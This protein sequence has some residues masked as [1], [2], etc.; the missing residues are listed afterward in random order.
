MRDKPVSGT[1]NAPDSSREENNMESEE[2][3]HGRDAERPQDIPKSG[4]RDILLR[5]KR[6]VSED[7]LSI[8]AAGVAFYGFLAIFPALAALVSS[9]GLIADAATVQSHLNAIRDFLPSEA[10]TMIQTQLKRIVEEQQSS[11]GW[12]LAGSIALAFWSASTGMKALFEAMNI[13]YDQEERRGFFK[14]NGLAILMTVGAV[15]L[16]IV[17]LALI[18]VLPPLLGYLPLPQMVAGLLRYVRW[19][20]MAALGLLSI[21]VLYRYG[22]SRDNPQWKWVSWGSASA[23]LLWLLGSSLFSLYVTHFGSY[24]E[25]Y[26]S[27]GVVVILM[28][29]LFISAY[30]VLIGSEVNAEMEH[31]TMKDTT[32]GARKPRGARDAYVADTVGKSP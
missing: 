2:K 28:M 32:T 11:L 17:F 6:E 25:T 4:W 16:M 14:L 31:Q 20:V 23:I 10:A 30:T 5:V 1:A 3:S 15:A 19:P 9:Y 18:A 7:N 27:L 29:W 13:T 8:V 12:A 24:G 26:G 21:S 22:P